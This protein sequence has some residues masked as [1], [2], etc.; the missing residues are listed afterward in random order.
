MPTKKKNP[1]LG[2][3]SGKSRARTPRLIDCEF[4]QHREDLNFLRVLIVN[5]TIVEGH[6]FRDF[7][8]ESEPR[9]I[10]DLRYSPKF[11][12]NTLGRHGFFEV[13]GG[14]N[15]LYLDMI[16]L[17][18]V[19]G[20]EE[21][22][23][24][25][26]ALF[27][28][29]FR[30]IKDN[31]RTV[32]GGI[33]MLTDKRSFSKELAYAVESMPH[34][35]GQSWVVETFPSVR[36][37]R[38]LKSPHTVVS[39]TTVTDQVTRTVIFISH[40]NPEDNDF[41]LWLSAKLQASGYQTW[42]DFENLRGGSIFWEEI[43]ETIRHQCAKFVFLQSAT[44]LKRSN[45]LNEVDLAVSV[46]RRQAL[47]NFVIPIRVDKSSFDDTYIALRRKLS[48]DCSIDWKRGLTDILEILDEDRV[49][50]VDSDAQISFHH[51]HERSNA[52]ET[53]VP[54]L[55]EYISNWYEIIQFPR[56]LTWNRLSKN[57][58]K[59]CNINS[60]ISNDLRFS[61]FH[62]VP[63]EYESD[64]Q[65]T[66]ILKDFLTGIS[67][68]EQT[69]TRRQ[70]HWIVSRLTQQAWENTMRDLG[71]RAY[72][73]SGYR[74]AWF[75]PGNELEGKK[76][77]YVD[78][79]GD[80]HS[81][82][83]IGRSRKYNVCWHFAAEAKLSFEGFCKV[84]LRPHVVF[85]RDGIVPLESPKLMHRLR[86]SFCKNWWNGRWRDLLGAFVQ[87]IATTDAL[88]L[89]AGNSQILVDTQPIIFVSPF[90]SIVE[91]ASTEEGTIDDVA[92]DLE[93][94]LE[95]GEFLDEHFA[96]Q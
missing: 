33:L 63:I 93:D 79:F 94:D 37:H 13:I 96:Q 75:W 34:P 45:V 66:I 16:G 70:A 95:L 28:I 78:A 88:S 5:M 61:F 20:K 81:R 62:E 54:R 25:L 26:Q 27:E 1:M 53:L 12:E 65:G 58:N 21:Y 15:A 77:S 19:E 3:V 51:W 59:I 46:E 84:V 4:S 48:I 6:E 60:I 44:S 31:R 24:D 69:I 2:V 32:P 73:M 30:W 49:P 86:R 29:V 10:V 89:Q 74:R 42:V 71:L 50:R 41:A 47:K 35:N 80:K 43:E 92:E 91:K 11:D 56:S 40:A 22:V 38:H 76:I 87:S 9:V 68:D 55:D 72:Q 39:D 83:L 18:Q 85:T 52:D 23:S 8:L 82:L 36:L 57:D 7:L 90:T 14:W 67:L 17:L 64:K